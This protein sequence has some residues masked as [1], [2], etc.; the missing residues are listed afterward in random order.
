M[1]NTQLINLINNKINGLRYD[2]D[3]NRKEPMIRIIKKGI[4]YLLI[5]KFCFK[6]F[7][8]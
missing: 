2:E 3:I 4:V 8:Q 6:I 1:N 7:E 5:I